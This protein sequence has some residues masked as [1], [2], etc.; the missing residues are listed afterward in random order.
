MTQEVSRFI[1]QQTLPDGRPAYAGIFYRSRLGDDLNN[2]A[3]F[4]HNQVDFVA[5]PDTD[6]R[7]NDPDFLAAVRL[8]GL[9]LK[10]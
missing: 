10:A 1:Y 9:R 2:W 6:I 3:I 4:E 7:P 8:L 5:D